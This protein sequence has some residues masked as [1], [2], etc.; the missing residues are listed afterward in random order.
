MLNHRP[1]VSEFVLVNDVCCQALIMVT[2]VQCNFT[3]QCTLRT[4]KII[5]K[6]MDPNRYRQVDFGLLDQRYNPF[7]ILSFRH[8]IWSLTWWHRFKQQIL[9]LLNVFV[10]LQNMRNDKI[11]FESVWSEYNATC[12]LHIV[13]IGPKSQES[14][15]QKSIHAQCTQWQCVL[16][17]YTK[18]KC[19][20][21]PVHCT[22]SYIN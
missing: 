15:Y 21:I 17:W 16:D 12:T 13:H 2:L 14:K 20:T 9:L 19:Y 11:D 10:R 22:R 5:Q 4:L 6:E 1:N 3:S 18:W 7:P 8:I